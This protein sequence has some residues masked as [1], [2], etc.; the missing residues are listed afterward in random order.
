MLA[1]LLGNSSWFAGA[2]APTITFPTSLPSGT[3]GT[4]YTT[5]QFLASGSPT[6]TWSITSGTLPTGLTFSSS[7]L[8][9]GTPTAAAAGPITF[10]A[11][12][13]I[14]SANAPLSL[15][16]SASG[17]S[18]GS[19]SAWE[20]LIVG[21]S[22]LYDPTLITT[23]TV[24]YVA[25]TGSDTTGDGTSGNPYLTIT[26]AAS[27]ISGGAGGVIYVKAGTYS[28]AVTL[29]AGTNTNYLRLRRYPGDAVT[30]S[31]GGSLA[32]AVT[33]SGG[34]V[35]VHG[36]TF[37]GYT[38]RAIT[39]ST[40]GTSY[41]FQY[42]TV[43]NTAGLYKLAANSSS[44]S[45]LNILYSSGTAATPVDAIDL[46]AGGCSAITADLIK[47]TGSGADSASPAAGISIATAGTTT[48]TRCLA[49]NF[50]GIAAD[51]NVTT[52]NLVAQNNKLTQTAAVGLGLL[53]INVGTGYTGTFE[54]N[55]I[56]RT[57][58]NT[59]GEDVV[60][61]VTGTGSVIIRRST[62][63]NGSIPYCYTI[64]DQVGGNLKLQANLII[65]DPLNGHPVVTSVGKP[66]A[67][68]ANNWRYNDFYAP[69]AITNAI[70]FD[71]T[72]NAGASAAVY[73][74]VKVIDGTFNS[75]WSSIGMV[76]NFATMP[77]LNDFN[78][79][80]F[81]L[82]ALD[83]ICV[84]KYL[85]NVLTQSIDQDGNNATVNTYMDIGCFE[86]QT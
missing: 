75:A 68:Q 57:A 36:I 79:L 30:M 25:K 32:N 6:I 3:I 16:V 9:S 62:I 39:S 8:L 31:G 18:S 85:D 4:V 38:S 60:S 82:D 51:L 24:K 58:D 53:K 81:R 83:T 77:A 61:I 84:N 74:L 13:S 1:T 56:Y 69:G 37:T 80:D 11:T 35:E 2:Q 47:L 72:A 66:A 86:R 5:T 54:N 29:P 43:T 76:G 21:A 78:G 28:E 27:V 44:I 52:G 73:T 67:S 33:L 46:S 23:G 71:D 49:T 15:T 65:Q 19:A 48:L 45:A 14:G 40:A 22:T 17:G 64:N 70:N 10:T 7:G 20:A 34:Y 42:L 50:S 26:K 12:N 59:F 41:T 55:L 63:W